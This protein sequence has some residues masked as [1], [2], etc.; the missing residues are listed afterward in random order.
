M[1]P[2]TADIPILMLTAD[3]DEE[4]IGQAFAA[5]AT[6]YMAKPPSPLALRFRAAGL[7]NAHRRNRQLRETETR[8][9]SVIRHASDAI[10]TLDQTLTVVSANPS[11]ANL[12]AAAAE[13]LLGRPIGELLAIAPE[14]LG[15]LPVETESC[16]P[17]APG[18]MVEVT[19]GEFHSGG[20]RFYTLIVRDITERKKAEN[21]LQEWQAMLRST[22]DTMSAHIAILDRNGVIMEVNEAWKRFARE[23]G[24]QSGNLA[25][26]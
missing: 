5:G 1:R 22:L 12:F 24:F 13:N 26:E 11:A 8:L 19:A 17:G 14:N 25:S 15:A 4:S 21:Q 20:K 16:F 23:N 6:D 9:Q 2:E 7:I 10:L 18:R 3:V